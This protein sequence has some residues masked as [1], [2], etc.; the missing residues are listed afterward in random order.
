MPNSDKLCQVFACSTLAG[1]VYS[2]ISHLQAAQLSAAQLSDAEGYAQLALVTLFEAIC[3][4]ADKRYIWATTKLYYS[5]FYS[6]RARLLLRDCSVFY[7]G[8]SPHSLVAKPGQTVERLKG[9]SHVA[10]F[11]IFR[12]QFQSDV[13]LSQPID[14]IDPFMWLQERRNTVSYTVA[15]STDPS[16]S[17]ELMKIHGKVRQHVQAYYND[18]KFIYAFDKDHALVAFPIEAIKAVDAELSRKGINVTIDKHFVDMVSG[19][20]CFVPEMRSLSGFKFP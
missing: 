17:A 11:D 13:L 20:S 15:P 14:A 8:H 3:G 1:K 9:N 12:K 5:T 4:V 19:A 18:R 16:A 7:I 2:P 6:I 10:T